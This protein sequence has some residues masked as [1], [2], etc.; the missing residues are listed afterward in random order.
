MEIK[1][2]KRT[3]IIV[4]YLSLLVT[5]GL[6]VVNESSLVSGQREYSFIRQTNR[7]NKVFASMSMNSS[8][9]CPFEL[10][11]VYYHA[12]ASSLLSF[13]IISNPLLSLSACNTSWSFDPTDGRTW[14]ARF[15][16]LLLH[17]YYCC[18]FYTQTNR[19][20]LPG[21]HIYL[22]LFRITLI[23]EWNHSHWNFRIS[24]RMRLPIKSMH[25]TPRKTALANRPPNTKRLSWRPIGYC[26]SDGCPWPIATIMPSRRW[27]KWPVCP[28]ICPWRT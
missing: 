20:W 1:S 21:Q 10:E 9:S 13:L 19:I 18:C 28:H 22:K 17:C 25:A 14:P 11:A 7:Q 12:V 27:I 3:I 5:L 6:V 15:W 8:W 24:F 2:A 26:R 23:C 4:Q 16:K